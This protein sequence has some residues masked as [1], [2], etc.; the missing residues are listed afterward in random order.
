MENNAEEQQLCGSCEELRQASLGV[1][2][3]LHGQKKCYTPWELRNRVQRLADAIKKVHCDPDLRQR[4]IM[5][6]LFAPHY[7]ARMLQLGGGMS[8]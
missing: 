6:S 5:F 7:L 4:A 2:E 8:G 1:V 3:L